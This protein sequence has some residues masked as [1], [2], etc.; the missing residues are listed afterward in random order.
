MKLIKENTKSIYIVDKE[1]FIHKINYK[2]I[3]IGKNSKKYS[4][5]TKPFTGSSILIEI[6]QNNYIYIRDKIYNFTTKEPIIK[7]YSTMGNNFVVYPFAL[8]ENYVYLLVENVYLEHDFGNIEPYQVYYDF[9][10]KWNRK[11]Y[12]FKIKKLN[13]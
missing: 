6:K 1:E 11:S 12:K 2:N 7:F 4:S 5:Y 10:K 3:F 13:S 8:T 9:K